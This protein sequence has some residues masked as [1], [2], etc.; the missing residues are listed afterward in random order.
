MGTDVNLAKD[1]HTL[2][3]LP[4]VSHITVLTGPGE[5]NLNL[6][7]QV[8]STL[9][10]AA[11]LP[12]LLRPPPHRKEAP[13]STPHQHEDAPNTTPFWKQPPRPQDYPLTHQH[14]PPT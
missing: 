6:A 5:V 11:G 9:L 8:E 13:H 4:T 12:V 1:V 10:T 14:D 2:L 7:M 3:I